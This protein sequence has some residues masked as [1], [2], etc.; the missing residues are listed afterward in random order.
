[1]RSLES[2]G[3]TASR[4]EHGAGGEGRAAVRSLVLTGNLTFS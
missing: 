4:K 1:M 3:M 2:P